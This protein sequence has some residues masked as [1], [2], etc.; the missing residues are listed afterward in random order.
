MSH[1]VHL[2]NAN[3]TYSTGTREWS[4]TPGD[5]AECDTAAG[6]VWLEQSSAKVKDIDQCKMSCEDDSGCKSITFFSDSNWCSHF[7]TTCMY[8]KSNDQ[9]TSMRLNIALQWSGQ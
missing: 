3:L 6:E 8:I 7:S 5:N 4:D 1:V 9:A 2:P